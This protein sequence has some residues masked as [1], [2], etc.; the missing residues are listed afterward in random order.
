MLSPTP[1]DQEA[2][3]HAAPSAEVVALADAAHL[4]EEGRA[5]FYAAGPEVL[6]ASAFAG[7]C[8][9]GLATRPLPAG[10]AVACYLEATNTIV[11]Y[12]PS[13]PRL[14]GFTVE[15][16]A[17]ETL[18]AA[19]A[20]MT[21]DQW[22]QLAPLLEAEVASL[23]VDDAIHEQ[24]AGSIGSHPQ[25]RATELFA[26]LGTQVWRDGGLAVEL[27]AA[28]ATVIADRAAL[29][30][31][32]TEWV[33]MLEVM[34]ADIQAA[35]QAL[36]DQ[37]ATNAQVRAHYAGDAASVEFYRQ[38]Y[39]AQAAEVARMSPDQRAHLELSWVWWDGTDLPLAPAEETLAAAADLLARD[40][41]DL[42]ARVAVITA[43]EDA[44][45]AE[46]VRIEGLAADLQ[47][48][49]AQLDPEQAS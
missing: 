19:W 42:P 22:A 1:G 47:A 26:Y 38:E 45:S 13:D 29:V 12:A 15:T 36:A 28:Y 6:G 39:Q 44:A 14:Q 7:R 46:R 11:V 23:P 18:H 33:G 17:H 27:E 10:A 43:A 4:S 8:A 49:Q 16:T 24:I 37:E 35:A 48:L 32:H 9:E 5:L 25:T 41:V 30:A 34:S 21:P 40:A 31:V 3:A 20:H 2:Q